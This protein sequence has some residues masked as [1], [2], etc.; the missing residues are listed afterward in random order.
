MWN[1]RTMPFYSK[2]EWNTNIAIHEDMM[3]CARA[4]WLAYTGL[5]IERL[6]FNSRPGQKYDSR[7][8]NPNHMNPLPTQL[9]LWVHWPYNVGGEMR[10]RGIRLAIRLHIPRLR[11]QSH[12]HSWTHGSRKGNLG[13]LFFFFLCANEQ[14]HIKRYCLDSQGYACCQ[15]SNDSILHHTMLTTIH[16]LSTNTHTLHMCA[17][18][19]KHM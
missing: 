15:W 10:Q 14:G 1:F 7:F 8:L 11:K 5:L 17:S 4:Q 3:G 12:Q 2:L 9:W 19:Y 13:E 18:L 16:Q 6:G